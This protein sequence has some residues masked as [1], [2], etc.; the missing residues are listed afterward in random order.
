MEAFDQGSGDI[1]R[2]LPGLSP[3]IG[4]WTG[5]LDK[6]GFTDKTAKTGFTFLSDVK[7]YRFGSKF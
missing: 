4:I 6:S 7:T 3:P 5:C 2:T 1:D